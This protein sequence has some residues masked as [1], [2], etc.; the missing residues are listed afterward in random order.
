MKLGM[1][2]DE[3]DQGDV[4]HIFESE[5]QTTETSTDLPQRMCEGDSGVYKIC[6]EKVQTEVA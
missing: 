5:R 4:W 6:D 2:G 1:C 3:K